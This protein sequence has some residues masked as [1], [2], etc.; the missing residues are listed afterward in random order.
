[1][2]STMAHAEARGLRE[3]GATV[4]LFQVPETL[5]EEILQ[6]MH[7]A[8]KYHRLYLKLFFTRNI[9]IFVAVIDTLLSNR[10]DD[11][12]LTYDLLDSLKVQHACLTHS[13]EL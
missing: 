11:P 10:G 5:S 4:D 2:P 3:G 9:G 7:A 8:P 1:M 13:T 6:K 12:V